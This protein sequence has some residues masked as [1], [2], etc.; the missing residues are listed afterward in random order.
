M[1]PS[2]A[3][4]SCVSRWISA[5]RSARFLITQWLVFSETSGMMRPIA[6][7]RWKCVSSNADLAGS[8]EQRAGERTQLGE[9]LDAGEAAADDD[10]RSAGG[11][12]RGRRAG[13]AAL[14]KL[15][16][17]RSRMATASSMVFRPMASSATPGIGNVR[18]TAPAVTTTMSYSSS[19]GSPTRRLDG[20]GLLGVVDVR[21]LGRDDVRLLEVATVGDDGVTRLDRAGGDLGQEGL[22]G[23]VREAGRRW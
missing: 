23:H 10:E 20:R 9:D 5:P 8:F 4:L 17:M 12:A 15:V 1:T 16:R 7:M 19:Y 11:R 3:V 14:S 18:E 21:D 6:S 22:V 13:C 2:T